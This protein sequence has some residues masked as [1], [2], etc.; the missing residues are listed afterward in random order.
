MACVADK[1]ENIARY[2]E[3]VRELAAEGAQIV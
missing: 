1:E 2:T 3:K